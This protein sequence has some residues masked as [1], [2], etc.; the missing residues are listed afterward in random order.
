MADPVT[1]TDALSNIISSFDSSVQ[2][3]DTG[4]FVHSILFKE[5]KAIRTSNDI[6][7][8]E[9]SYA[10]AKISSNGG[11]ST[12]NTYTQ[13]TNYEEIE[14]VSVP[15]GMSNKTASSFSATYTLS[16]IISSV[17]SNYTTSYDDFE[18]IDQNYRKDELEIKLSL[19]AYSLAI[20]LTKGLPPYK[21]EY[22]ER[23]NRDIHNSSSFWKYSASSLAD[24]CVTELLSP[25]YRIAHIRINE[26]GT[27][28]D[29]INTGDFKELTLDSLGKDGRYAIFNDIKDQIPA[30]LSLSQ[31]AKGYVYN[32]L[33]Y[34][35]KEN[36]TVIDISNITNLN[37]LYV[38]FN[39]SFTVN[40]VA[41]VTLH[42]SE[43]SG[44][45]Y[46]TEN[47]ILPSCKL[48]DISSSLSISG[49]NSEND[50]VLDSISYTFNDEQET[51]DPLT[52]NR[53]APPLIS[54]YS[55][56]K[57]DESSGDA[58]GFLTASDGDVYTDS[59]K[60]LEF[61]IS[62]LYSK[63]PNTLIY[64]KIDKGLYTNTAT[65]ILSGSTQYGT[66][67]CYAYVADPSQQTIL[68]SQ[69]AELT[70]NVYPIL[71]A[72][73][74]TESHSS[75]S[76]QILMSSNFN[77]L[78]STDGHDPDVKY[79]S[80][81][82][83]YVTPINISRKT[84][85]KAVSVYNNDVSGITTFTLDPDTIF[86]TNTTA[87]TIKIEGSSTGIKYTE[88][89]KVTFSG[90]SGV[91]YYTLDGSDPLDE[92]NISRKVYTSPFKVLPISTDSIKLTVGT[93]QQ[94]YHSI[95]GTTDGTTYSSESIVIPFSFVCNPWK[96]SESSINMKA[97]TITTDNN[98]KLYAGNMIERNKAFDGDFYF[99]LDLLDVS[100]NCSLLFG[101]REAMSIV[102][103]QAGDE[104]V[105]NLKIPAITLLDRVGDVITCNIG[106]RYGIHD[107]NHFD[108]IGKFDWNIK[109]PLP[110][111]GYI[112]DEIIVPSNTILYDANEKPFIRDPQYNNELGI[113]LNGTKSIIVRNIPA[114]STRVVIIPDSSQVSED[115]SF[116]VTNLGNAFDSSIILQHSYSG[117][118]IIPGNKTAVISNSSD[119]GWTYSIVDNVTAYTINKKIK[120]SINGYETEYSL[121]S[122]KE[123]D[124]LSIMLAEVNNEL[125]SSVTLGNI[126]GGCF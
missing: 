93:T 50:I 30:G 107:K 64:S 33:K 41:I 125:D 71:Q 2:T 95:Y 99:T 32:E 78:Y 7:E 105:K 70:I 55:V 79:R 14:I 61:K 37:K 13:Y 123:L 1:I 34:P 57:D 102:N 15:D 23:F 43:D 117:T 29:N 39:V 82:A 49:K 6:I 87:P 97:A 77:I 51:A 42:I 27:I 20:V 100:G 118:N 19:G 122:M 89:A 48:I 108:M 65:Q 12:G 110:I 104:Y 28:K 66:H 31:D 75:G 121:I 67:T 26:N 84:V 76:I 3:S 47:I 58:N 83:L 54:A 24:I 81:V 85:I 92:Y 9:Q 116:S 44:N 59:I 21:T 22:P 10:G 8:P 68:Q 80:N 25:K 56:T 113:T 73:V 52:G 45:T 63:I 35:F 4:N 103:K 40:N 36:N 38:T 126:T 91:V 106:Y 101:L 124:Y 119:N 69:V 72:P 18:K 90:Y 62:S 114:Y 115:L 94:G 109:N 11:I 120:I 16:S 96:I 74:I 46:S 53:Y 17:N 112:K 60:D 88:A 86:T 98:L 5:G 111:T